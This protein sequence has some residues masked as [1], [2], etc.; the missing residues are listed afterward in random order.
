VGRKQRERKI[1][2]I[3]NSLAKMYR[4]LNRGKTAISVYI[5]TE[6]CLILAP[7]SMMPIAR[8]QMQEDVHKRLAARQRIFSILVGKTKFHAVR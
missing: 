2:T 8:K 7:L 3:K 5:K 4:M 6:F 1:S